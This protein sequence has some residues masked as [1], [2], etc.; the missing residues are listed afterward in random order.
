MNSGLPGLSTIH[1]NSAHD[2]V[3]KLCTLPLLA[4]ENISSAFVV[5][6]VAACIDLVVHCRKDPDGHRYVGEI[7][8]LGRRVENG[9]IETTTLFETLDGVLQLAP[10]ADLAHPKLVDA[11]IDVAEL[12]RAVA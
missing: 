8:G 6:T 1:A 2:A 9:A 7:L 12:G 3:T 5:P 4:G 11:G 10:A